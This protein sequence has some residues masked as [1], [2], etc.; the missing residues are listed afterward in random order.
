MLQIINCI[1]PV[2]QM[3]FIKVCIIFERSLSFV[4]RTSMSKHF[5]IALAVGMLT[6]FTIAYL[7]LSSS[8]DYLWQQLSDP[9]TSSQLEGI[10]GPLRDPGTHSKD[11]VF[12]RM[13]DSTVADQLAQ[14]IRILCWV[15]TGPRNHDKRAKHVKNTWGKRCN[16]LLFMSS[17]EGYFLFV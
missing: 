6:G 15:M 3:L 12:H 1:N 13:E 17:I 2:I 4:F 5:I 9:H 7:I 11:E 14:Q 16:I 10:S 8:P